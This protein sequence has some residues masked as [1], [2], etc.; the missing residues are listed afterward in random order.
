[1]PDRFIARTG[2]VNTPESAPGLLRKDEQALWIEWHFATA[3]AR[4]QFL[5]DYADG[6]FKK[7]KDLGL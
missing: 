5:K 4:E 1:M 2:H 3:Q 6:K 7:P